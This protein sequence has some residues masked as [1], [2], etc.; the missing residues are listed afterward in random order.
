MSL[1]LLRTEL[2]GLTGKS[3]R[4]SKLSL[5]VLTSWCR[6]IA[7]HDEGLHEQAE[8]NELFNALNSY[9]EK[10]LLAQDVERLNLYRKN[11]DMFEVLARELDEIVRKELLSR[12]LCYKIHHIKVKDLFRDH[13]PKNPNRGHPDHRVDQSDPTATLTEPAQC[14]QQRN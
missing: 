10:L 12:L 9:I 8:T 14:H 6:E 7:K 3:L 5:E 11:S 13:F 4:P 1:L 2:D